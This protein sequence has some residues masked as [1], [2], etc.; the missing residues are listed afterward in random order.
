MIFRGLLKLGVTRASA[1]AGSFPA[2]ALR[3][4]PHLTSDERPKRRIILPKSAQLCDGIPTQ[5]TY[6]RMKRPDRTHDLHG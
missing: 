1:L 5:T 3:Q 2:A 4:K 6:E